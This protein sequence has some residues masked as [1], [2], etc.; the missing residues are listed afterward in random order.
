MKSLVAKL[1]Q[2]ADLCDTKGHSEAAD[3]ID[4]LIVAHCGTCGIPKKKKKKL[5]KKAQFEDP[6]A[7]YKRLHRTMQ[8]AIKSNKDEDIR[9]YLEELHSGHV[10]EQDIADFRKRH[11]IEKVMYICRGLPGSGKSTLAK[12]LAGET[13]AIYSTD[14]FFMEGGEYKFDVEKIAENHMKNQKRTEEACE[15]GIS[16]IVVDNTNLQKWE[17]RPYVNIAKKCG[18]KVEFVESTT[19]WSKNVE[20]LAKRNIHKVPSEIIERMLSRY[21]PHEEF[22]EESVLT[23]KAPWEEE[24]A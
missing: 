22:T 6:F 12:S 11:K 17:A 5:K 3:Q 8:E 21:E 13:G 24:A 14:D 4:R 1:T 15:A 23:S 18:Y 19:S 20:E 10:T 2:L 7:S 16:P 9:E